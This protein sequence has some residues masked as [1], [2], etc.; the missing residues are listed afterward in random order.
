MQSSFSLLKDVS[1]IFR[2]GQVI[3]KMWAPFILVWGKFKQLTADWN[4]GKGVLSCGL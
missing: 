3:E 4:G 1:L 2:K